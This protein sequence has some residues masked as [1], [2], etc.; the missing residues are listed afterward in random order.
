MRFSLLIF[1]VFNLSISQNESIF[2]H[3]KFIDGNDTLNYRLLIP[4]KLKK[5]VN[6]HYIYFYMDLGR[7][8]MIINSN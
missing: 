7:E 6:I 3:K 4:K 8:E 5:K 1:L 2:L